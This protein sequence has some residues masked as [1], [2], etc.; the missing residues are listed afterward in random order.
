MGKEAEEMKIIDASSFT[1]STGTGLAVL[2]TNY[3]YFVVNN[4]KEPRIR[5][6][7]DIPGN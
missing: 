1:S 2:T 6:F 5:R 3:R 7:P 4:V